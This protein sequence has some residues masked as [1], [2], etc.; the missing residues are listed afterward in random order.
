MIDL[1]FNENTYQIPGSWEELTPNQ[2]LEIIPYLMQVM[3]T[4]ISVQQC[5]VLA[6]LVLMGLK[7]RRFRSKM[8]ETYFNENTY[9]ISLELSFL[10]RIEYENNKAFSKLNKEIREKL[11]RYI[12]SELDESIP[13]V[14]WASKQK[15]Q[16]I[17]DLVFAKNLMP[18]IGRGRHQLKGYVFELD[19]KLLSSSLTFIQFVDAQFLS[20]QYLENGNESTLRKLVTTLY[21]PGKYN[22]D[23]AQNV[24]LSKVD[25]PQ[26]MAILFNFNAVQAFLYTRTKYRL[27]F[28]DSDAPQPETGKRKKQSGSGLIGMGYQLTKLGYA[29]VENK[30]VIR[31]FDQMY[32]EVVTNV[33]ILH[34]QEIPL[35]KISEATGLSIRKINQILG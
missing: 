11:Y 32:N 26:M 2:Y 19:G 34:Q 6:A 3:N 15:F 17:P 35:D 8:H 28:D 23:Q 12:P 25:F 22:Q 21:C 9:R 18:T 13:E 4:E 20:G 33:Q 5:R 29:D 14:R 30:S 16:V 24:Q 31:A 7:P 1:H 27:L 10:F